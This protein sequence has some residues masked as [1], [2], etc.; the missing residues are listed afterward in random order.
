[1]AV[2]IRLL[3]RTTFDEELLRR[4]AE[5]FA[6]ARFREGL[7]RD[8]VRLLCPASQIPARIAPG[9]GTPRTHD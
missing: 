9:V 8:V 5:R 3:E 2:A 4:A 1:M 7:L 6:P